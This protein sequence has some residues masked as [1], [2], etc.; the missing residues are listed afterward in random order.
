MYLVLSNTARSKERPFCVVAHLQLFVCELS[1]AVP[2][3][4]LLLEQF[5]VAVLS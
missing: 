4:A 3:L 5:V 2:F 1:V